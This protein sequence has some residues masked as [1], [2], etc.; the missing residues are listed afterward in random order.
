MVQAINNLT[1]DTAIM[2]EEAA[3]GLEAALGMEV[4]ETGKVDGKEGGEGTQR[5]LVSLELLTQ[6]YEPRGT[7]LV[8]AHNGF[9]D[10]SRLAIL[11]TVRHRWP[12]GASFTFNCY[13]HWAQLI[14]RHPGEPPVTILSREGV[15]QGDPLS[16]VFNGITLVPIAEELIVAD[17]GL[18]LP[19]TQMMRRLMVRHDVVHSY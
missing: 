3:D 7:T 13:R 9:N 16:I 2:E 8:D 4:E 1:I 11:W 5:A 6:E 10:L 15:T 14:L 17:P 18:L 12:A 19:F